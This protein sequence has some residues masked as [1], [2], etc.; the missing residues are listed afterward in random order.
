[1]INAFGKDNVIYI[2]HDYYYKDNSKLTFRERS[3]INFDHPDSLDT[4]LLVS[5]L[6]TLKEGRH[7]H[8]PS[9]DFGTHSR[10]I[11]TEIIHPNRIII[12]DGILLLNDPSLLSTLDFKIYVDASDKTRLRRRIQ[13]DVAERQ[14]S[15]TSVLKQ[16]YKT[17]L[18]MHKLYVETSKSNADVILTSSDNDEFDNIHEKHTTR[19]IK[20]LLCYADSSYHNNI[21]N[22]NTINKRNSLV[23]YN[24]PY[25]SINESSGNYNDNVHT[26]IS[27]FCNHVTL[28]NNRSN[29]NNTSRSK[30]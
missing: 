10:R 19:T 17:V 28:E 4:Q 24:G 13:R 11:Q 30:C 5:H 22:L 9:Y 2:S 20:D 3:Q 27:L 8:V 6:K 7:V 21:S 26:I 23:E 12:V 14:R 18:P 16:F 29:T 1:L 15:I 25:I